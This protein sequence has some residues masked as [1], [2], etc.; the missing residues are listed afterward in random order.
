M[1]DKIKIDI[2]CEEVIII[3]ESTVKEAV[4]KHKPNTD[5]II[6]ANDGYFD[7][8]YGCATWYYNKEAYSPCMIF[9]QEV[10]ENEIA[11]EAAHI[12]FMIMDNKGLPNTEDN[13]EVFC[14]IIGYIVEKTVNI[15]KNA[16]IKNNKKREIRGNA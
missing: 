14:Y 2:F 8:A 4:L 3:Q 9:Q 16:K 7:N 5:A 11:H 1:K 10:T 6:K 13:E 15:L 12:T